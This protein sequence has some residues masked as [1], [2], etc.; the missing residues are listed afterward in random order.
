[1]LKKGMAMEQDE[2]VPAFAEKS[3]SEYHMYT[4]NRGV[5]LPDN[6]TKQM[7]LIPA[8]ADVPVEKELVYNGQQ[9]QYWNYGGIY[10][11]RNYGVETGNKKVD[12]FLKLQNKKENGL[13]VPLPSGRIR[14]NQRDEDGAQE[15]IGE[16]IIDHTPRNEEVVIKLGSAFDVVGERTQVDYKLDTAR[17]TAEEEIEIKIRNQKKQPVK[18]KVVEN[19]YRATGWEIINSSLKYNKDAAHQI[20]FLA[21]VAP[22]KEQ[23]IHYLVKYTW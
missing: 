13:G 18:V 22:E 15:F 11:D 8:V 4:L 14:V 10:T 2:R 7:E 12:V 21:D 1:M 3:F 17:R 16:S 20:S 19:L 9:N 5:T 6:S 23:T